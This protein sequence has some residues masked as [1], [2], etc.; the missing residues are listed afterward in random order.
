MHQREK[1]KFKLNQGFRQ[2]DGVSF[3]GDTNVT[4][5]SARNFAGKTP[6][7]SDS[8]L[9]SP[10]YNAQPRSYFHPAGQRPKYC[11][12]FD[13]ERHTKR[14]ESHLSSVGASYRGMSSPAGACTVGMDTDPPEER[15]RRARTIKRQI[16]LLEAARSS[17]PRGDE[18][19]PM[20]LNGRAQHIEF[21]RTTTSIELLEIINSKYESG[22][23]NLRS[24]P[25]EFVTIQRNRLVPHPHAVSGDKLLNRMYARQ[26]VCVYI[27][28][29][30]QRTEPPLP[31]PQPQ[32]ANPPEQGAENGEMDIVEID[33]EPAPPAQNGPGDGDQGTHFAEFT[34]TVEERVFEDAQEL[35]MITPTI[36]PLDM[37]EGLSGPHVAALLTAEAGIGRPW[38]SP[39]SLQAA[40]DICSSQQR[41]LV[42]MLGLTE[43]TIGTSIERYTRTENFLK[44]LKNNALCIHLLPDMKEGKDF[45]SQHNIMAEEL[46][47]LVF[48][49]VAER[50][51]V[52]AK[53]RDDVT[54]PTQGLLV[55]VK[56]EAAAST[57]GLLAHVKTEAAASTQGLLAHVE[58]EAAASTQG[59]LAH[60]ETGA[61]ASTQGLLAH[62]ETGAAASTQGLL[63]HVETEAAASTQGLLAHVET[64]AVASTQG[65][66]VHE[67]TEAAASTQGLLAHV[68]TEAAASTQGLLAHVETEAAASTQGLLAHVE[69]EAAASTQG[70][71]AHVETGAAASTQGLLAH[72]KTEAAASTQGLLVHV[73]TG[74]VASTQGLLVHVKT[75]AAASTQGLLAH[76]KTEA[77]ASTQ[78][79]LAHVKM[80][81]AASTQGLLVHVKTEAAASTQGL[82]VHVKTEAAASSQGLL[83]HVELGAAAST[84]GLLVHVDLEADPSTHGLEAVEGLMPE[85]TRAE[86]WPVVPTAFG[87]LPCSPGLRWSEGTSGHS[88]R[89]KGTI[90]SQECHP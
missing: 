90:L 37:L 56:T 64:G 75:E 29:R 77:A 13:S 85:A 62:V 10:T 24:V 36:P 17:V 35:G 67:K 87:V 16:Y 51:A 40:K 81:A 23:I 31:Q 44:Y 83:V 2:T 12:L 15:P 39:L 14:V 42:T 26:S 88:G 69:T 22:G 1:V 78:G 49:W 73:E 48:E 59:L 68:K 5:S 86:T 52:I 79:L 4:W 43:S 19:G 30:G 27:R 76:V 32:A 3:L 11:T 28:K 9:S 21:R 57:Q 58:T 66:L 45:M 6:R 7:T 54:P 18:R 63:A 20:W 71:L 46:P 84:Q 72:V 47:A 8:C 80:E 89:G 61:A 70:L 33:N 65:L 74:A 55:H 25:W 60:V 50:S 82:L 53:S 41:P 34:E 38:P